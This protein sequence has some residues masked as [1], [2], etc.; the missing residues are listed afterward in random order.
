MEQRTPI[1]GMQALIFL[2]I[3]R[4][5]ELE[6]LFGEELGEVLMRALHDRLALVLPGLAQIWRAEPRRLAI[7][8]PGVGPDSSLALARHLQAEA[9]R[10]PF[11]MPEGPI[12]VTLGV[13]VAV[14]DDPA[15][16]G[17][18]ARRALHGALA[19][20]TGALRLGTPADSV[21]PQ[22]TAAQAAMRA[23]AADGLSLACQ[24]VMRADVPGQVAF[25]ECLARLAT[26][27]GPRATAQ[28]FMP[29]L[30]RLG[31]APHV[32]RQVLTLAL[33]MLA[34]QPR[35]RL[36][37]NVSPHTM[38]DAEWGRLFDHATARAPG[39]ADRLIV[40]VT[41]TAAMLD[42]GRTA[43]FID[44]LREAG[45]ALALDDFGAGHTSLISLRD[46]RFDI[47][48]LD[49]SFARGIATSADNRFLVG[50][51]VAIARHFDMM[52]VA[53]GVEQ[54]HEP[55]I[56]ADLGVDCLQGYLFG[57]PA[58]LPGPMEQAAIRQARIA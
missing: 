30:E 28:S 42:G 32:D 39:L 24:P 43:R 31:M 8:L 19:A 50:Q 29:Q 48:K 3:D 10:R 58:I 51:M 22:S 15:D 9:A 55:R 33:A 5:G 34:E 53:E 57:Q 11:V 4:M 54:P 56:L 35:A 18:V 21:A 52:T 17:P 6:A 1:Q 12:A 37:I 41:E 23:L 46:F 7:A 40:E 47:V 49:A 13:G 14:G 2:A 20:G 16:L 45:A 44:R 38:Q 26:P 27:G 25:H 36:S